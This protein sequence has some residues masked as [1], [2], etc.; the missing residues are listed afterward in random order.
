MRRLWR[1]AGPATI[2]AA[3]YVLPR[4]AVALAEGPMAD[5]GDA[6]EERGEKVRPARRAEPVVVPPRVPP[7]AET[8]GEDDEEKAPVRDRR[9]RDGVEGN[10]DEVTATLDPSPWLGL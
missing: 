3:D 9:S 10:E 4:P 1:G 8:A 7:K 6:E 2:A 5:D